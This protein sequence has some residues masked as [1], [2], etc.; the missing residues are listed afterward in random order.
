VILIDGH[1]RGYLTRT[2][3]N[4][5]T[6]LAAEDPDRTIQRQ[7][8]AKSLATFAH[9]GQPVFIATIDHGVPDMHELARD[10]AAAGFIRTSR[11]YLHRGEKATVMPRI[12][13][14]ADSMRM[15][16]VS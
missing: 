1:L 10:L 2:G 7:T 11:G 8:L 4:L 6:F 13:T 16:E 15:P 9:S 5:M 14:A 3:Q 12:T